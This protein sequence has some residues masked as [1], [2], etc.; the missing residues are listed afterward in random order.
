MH[1][2]TNLLKRYSRRTY[3]PDWFGRR[4]VTE[5]S[6]ESF[7]L[8]TSWEGGYWKYINKEGRGYEKTKNCHPRTI[9]PV[10]SHTR[11]LSSCNDGDHEALESSNAERPV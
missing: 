7:R 2:I 11:G 1:K 5:K 9:F 8:F 3:G 10:D 6:V 4:H